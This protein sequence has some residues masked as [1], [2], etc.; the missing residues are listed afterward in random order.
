MIFINHRINRVAAL[1][2]V[3]LTHGCE[4]DL[5]SDPATKGRIYLAHDPWSAGDD[6]EDWLAEFCR[7]RLEGPII[8]NTKEDG[9]ERRIIEMLGDA[10]LVNW[11]FLDTAFPTLVRYTLGLRERR[12]AVRVSAYEPPSGADA[13]RGAAEWAWVDCFGGNPVP[14]DW[15]A[16][17]RK[18]FRVC[19]VSPELQAPPTETAL[20]QFRALAEHADAICTKQSEK[21][22][23]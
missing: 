22:I 3:P 21:W 23:Y 2:G 14:A 6:F 20:E 15:C 11:F 5:R 18:D 8:L 16:D 12:F 13:F 17:L 1:K 7:M 10:G 4:I 19:L 9:L